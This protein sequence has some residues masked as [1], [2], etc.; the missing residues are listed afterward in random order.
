MERD[1]GLRV[2]KERG[3]VFFIAVVMGRR[4]CLAI[5]VALHFVLYT[6]PESPEAEGT[7]HCHDVELRR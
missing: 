3:V 5:Y 4:L 1:A 6:L 2:Q 7:Y